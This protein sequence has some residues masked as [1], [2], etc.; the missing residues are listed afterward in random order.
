[1]T[2]VSVEVALRQT[3][4]TKMSG[5]KGAAFGLALPL[6]DRGSCQM[7]LVVDGFGPKMGLKMAELRSATARVS[8]IQ[9]QHL[10]SSYLSYE[11]RDR[12]VRSAIARSREAAGVS[13]A[14]I[15]GRR[16]CGAPP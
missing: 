12:G 4:M 7:C 16:G 14:P 6:T 13:G 8:A 15:V 2:G 1:M 10:T 3:W 9:L 5:Q 11:A